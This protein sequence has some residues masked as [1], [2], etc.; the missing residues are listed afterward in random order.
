VVSDGTLHIKGQ[1]KVGAEIILHPSRAARRDARRGR[2]PTLVGTGGITPDLL[3]PQRENLTPKNHVIQGVI[4]ILM[5]SKF[6]FQDKGLVKLIDGVVRTVN[7]VMCN[8]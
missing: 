5:W 2:G 8:L 6:G 1:L 3:A 7:H 4:R